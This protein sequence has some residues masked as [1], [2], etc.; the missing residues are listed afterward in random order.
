MNREFQHWLGIT[1]A[2]FRINPHWQQAFGEG[3]D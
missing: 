2:A 1:P 3:Y